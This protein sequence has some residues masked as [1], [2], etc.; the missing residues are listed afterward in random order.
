M[1]R[2]NHGQCNTW[3]FIPLH[4]S[5]GLLR[6]EERYK[7]IN[8]SHC[9]KLKTHGIS[10]GWGGDHSKH[11]YHPAPNLLLGAERRIKFLSCVA[12]SDTKASIHKFI[13]SRAYFSIMG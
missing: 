10:P 5:F 9:F 1:N 12:K 8:F 11:R 2:G 4:Q 13:M 6:L 7:V 3:V